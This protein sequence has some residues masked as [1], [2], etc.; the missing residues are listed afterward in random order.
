MHLDQKSYWI[1]DGNSEKK[2][3]GTKKCVIKGRVKIDNYK[4]NK[5]LN[6]IHNIALNCGDDRITLYPY[7]TNAGKVCKAELLEYVN[8]IWLILMI[9]L[10]KIK[11]IIIKRGHIIQIIHTEY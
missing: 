1:D 6:E 2:P 10:M 8:I 11:Q 7:N 3:K 4:N 5:N 9:I